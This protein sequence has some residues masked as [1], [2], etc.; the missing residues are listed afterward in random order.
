MKPL[1]TFHNLILINYTTSTKKSLNLIK[2]LSTFPTLIL[3]NHPT[4]TKITKPHQS[5]INASQSHPNKFPNLT[6]IT[7]PHQTSIKPM[8]KKITQPQQKSANIIKLFSTFPNLILINHVTSS[9]IT[10]PHPNKSP[11]LNKNQQTSSNSSSSI[12]F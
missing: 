7:Q 2:P 10:I 6:K 4:S 3:I 9:N 11:N 12:F 5:S 1:S 8:Y